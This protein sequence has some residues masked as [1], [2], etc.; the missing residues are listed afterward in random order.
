MFGKGLNRGQP[1]WQSLAM[2]RIIEK[3]VSAL[4]LAAVVLL[5]CESGDAKSSGP[6][7][8]GQDVAGAGTDVPSIG[9]IDLV[10][11]DTVGSPDG[12]TPPGVDVSAAVDAGT[13]EDGGSADATA[14]APDTAQPADGVVPDDSVG[15]DDVAPPGD[16]AISDD[17]PAPEDVAPPEDAGPPIAPEY[18]TF[19]GDWAMQP[20]KETTRCVVKRLDNPGT[21]WIR[22]VETT[23]SKGSHHLVV[24]KSGA[25]EEQTEPFPCT[26][27]VETIA[28]DTYPLL[29]SQI[30]DEKL[31]LP[32]GVAFKFEPYQMVRIEAHYLNYY[33]EEITAHAEVT[34]RTLPAAEVVHEAGL[35]FYGTP[36]FKLPPGQESATDWFFL[37]VWQDKKVFAMT[38][39]T[40]QYGTNVEINYMTGPG[41]TGTPI[42]PGEKP[43]QWDEAPIVSFDPPLAFDG[44]AGFQYR[45]T[46]FNSSNKTVDFGESASSE[47]CFFW[48]YY[49]PS[50]GYRLCINPGSFKDLAPA[51]VVQDQECCPDSPLCDLIKAYLAG[52]SGFPF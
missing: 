14:V 8:S 36:D 28:G 47:M 27:F 52:G 51:G 38:G 41:A 10:E 18:T 5:G 23:L 12:G 22:A 11:A 17:A 9:L 3:S 32:P 6:A 44:Q 16:T 49:Y 30:S 19:I 50:D 40:H 7:A 35:L 29:I 34:F 25:T 46:W 2:I 15:P 1:V 26:P 48:A 21:A 39:H 13:Q 24:Y 33:P 43:F 31:V 37:D 42:Y 20:G 4:C 45:C